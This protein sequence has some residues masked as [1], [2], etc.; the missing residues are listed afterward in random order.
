MAVTRWFKWIVL[1]IVALSIR[2]FPDLVERYQEALV[3]L[4]GL[5]A[6]YYHSR[7]RVV[8]HLRVTGRTLPII[9]IENVGNRA[10]KN[11]IV[12]LLPKDFAHDGSGQAK[13]EEPIGDMPPGY[14][15]EIKV[16][17]SWYKVFTEDLDEN[18][19]GWKDWEITVQWT[20]WWRRVHRERFVFRLGTGSLR[21]DRTIDNWNTLNR[22]LE[23]I[24]KSTDEMGR[25]VERLAT[26]DEERI[27]GGVLYLRV[28]EI[29]H[30]MAGPYFVPLLDGDQ[31][32]ELIEGA[33]SA[34]C[35]DG[36]PGPDGIPECK[37]SEEVVYRM[38]MFGGRHNF[39][40]GVDG[41][42]DQGIPEGI[43]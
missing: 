16:R 39:R 34:M 8:A 38:A 27:G 20:V 41:A 42:S 33:N 7:P 2:V 1:V 14:T 4:G 13:R 11:V 32:K 3:G 43:V 9:D 25:Q 28:G 23:N 21:G 10:A 30:S 31:A 6:W 5:G 22:H 19:E 18:K 29:A 37:H 26:L 12:E 36:T 35:P 15:R 40:W 17:K 24:H